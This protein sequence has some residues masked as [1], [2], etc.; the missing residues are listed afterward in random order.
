[1]HQTRDQIREQT[2]KH[3]SCGKWPTLGTFYAN[4]PIQYPTVPSK[5]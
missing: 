2:T 3:I 1:M 5:A 4:Y